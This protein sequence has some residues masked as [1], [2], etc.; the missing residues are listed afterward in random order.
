MTER[1]TKIPAGGL[2]AGAM[3]A[4]LLVGGCQSPFEP[5]SADGELRRSIH[6]AIDR[7][8]AMLPPIEQRLQTTQPPAEAERELRERRE[9]LD[10]LVPA[11]GERPRTFELGPDLTG[12]DQREVGL[13]LE[14]AI[15]AAV[16]NNLSVQIAR[17]Q[18]AISEADV[19]AAE[20]AFDAIFFSSADLEWIDQPTTQPI[21]NNIPVGTP[22][23]VS[24]RQRFETGIRKP[25]VTGGDVSLSTEVLRSTSRTPGVQIFPDPAYA[26]ALSLGFAQPLLRGFGSDVNR[27]AIRL[28]RNMERRTIQQLRR[29]LMTTIAEMER[30]Y[31]DLV[32][33]WKNLEIQQWLVDKGIEVRDVLERRRDFDARPAEYAD[34]VAVVEQR[35]SNVIR[36]RRQLRA[37][38]DRLKLLIND[39]ELAVGSE[40]VVKP[41]DEVSGMPI[42]YSLRDAVMTAVGHRP[43]VQEAILGI[44]DASIRQLLADNA[45]M[46]QLNLFGRITYAGLDDSFSDSYDELFDGRFISY[47]LGL[48]FEM[49]IGNRGA[50]AEYRQARLR[51]T[52]AA[53]GYQQVVQNV[54]LD[55]KNALRDVVTNYELIQATRSFRVAQAENLRALRVREE[56]IGLTPEFLNLM[57]QRQ[58]T[59][60]QA[61][62]EEVQAMINFDQAVAELYRAMGIGLTMNRIE[63]ELIDDP[64][65]ERVGS[66]VAHR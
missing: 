9:E 44:D 38:S 13:S 41:I 52:S 61:R 21:I 8:L 33:A 54:I 32:F 53:I 25:L 45:R 22:L 60:A 56:L 59:L 30:A 47:L 3:A 18:P 50:E 55:V 63:I 17:L 36:A 48:A 29:E 5:V 40:L 58:N 23:Q 46:P 6:A 65:Q 64:W 7:E 42:S 4:I 27:S 43:E 24:R 2:T 26:S 34:A 16:S 51:R 19:V 20:A 35:R 1:V 66:D 10:R 28:A 39:P 57:F 49:P 12:Q 62:S 37:A 14:A 15:R 31:W 11:L